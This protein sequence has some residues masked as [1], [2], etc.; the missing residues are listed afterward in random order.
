MDSGPDLEIASI[1][2]RGAEDGVRRCD[3][4]DVWSKVNGSI[5]TNLM[6][7]EL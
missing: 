7:S 4:Q 1:K 5:K 2:M 6:P 3:S